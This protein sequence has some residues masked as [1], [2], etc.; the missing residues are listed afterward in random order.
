[1]VLSVLLCG[2]ALQEPASSREKITVENVTLK[3]L[4]TWWG[5]VLGSPSN[6]HGCLAS[7]LRW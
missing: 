2:G 5:Q 3:T 6:V 4:K 7:G 1:M